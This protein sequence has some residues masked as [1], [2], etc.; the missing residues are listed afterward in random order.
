MRPM[1]LPPS[2][3]RTG[4]EAVRVADLMTPNPIS[5]RH[6]ATIREAALFLTKWRIGAAP[7]VNDAGRAVGVLSRFDVLL[8]VNAGVDGAPVREVMTPSVIAVRPH[9]PALDALDHMVRHRVRRVFVVD[10]EGVPFGVVSM[11]D[12]CRGLTA[13]WSEPSPHLEPCSTQE[14]T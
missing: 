2:P 9:T 1:P 4:L 6:G 10:D 11:T 3:R 8:A 7:V 13:R 14:C 5:V 12:L